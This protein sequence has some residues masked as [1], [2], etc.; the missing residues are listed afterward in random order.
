MEK[1]KLKTTMSYTTYLLAQLT[2][3]QRTDTKC[4]QVRKEIE[5]RGPGMLAHTWNFGTWEVE[6][7]D[8]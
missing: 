1:F 8:S 7:E 4:W 6:A 2:T 3:E 5:L